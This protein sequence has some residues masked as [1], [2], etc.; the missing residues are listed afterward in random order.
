[1]ADVTA[2]DQGLL[3]GAGVRRLGDAVTAPQRIPQCP[4]LIL[5]GVGV[6]SM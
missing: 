2:E 6:L 4:P 5:L 3:R 1:M